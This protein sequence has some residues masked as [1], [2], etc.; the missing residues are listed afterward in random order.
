MDT[1][2]PSFTI[3]C[4]TCVMQHTD[5]CNDCVVSFICSRDPG[6]AVVVDLQGW[7]LNFAIVGGLVPRSAAT[8]RA[9]RFT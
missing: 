7:S 6:D 3:D 4:D 9:D 1:P 8:A 5:A 2:S